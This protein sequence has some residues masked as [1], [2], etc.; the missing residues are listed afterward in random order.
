[1]KRRGTGLKLLYR[2]IGVEQTVIGV[3]KE[4]HTVDQRP[5][6]GIDAH[7]CSDIAGGDGLFEAGEGVSA[8]NE[9]LADEPRVAGV[10]Q[11]AADG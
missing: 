9:L 2:G 7:V 4:H 1:M 10:G 5:M 3:N 11:G 6:D 8:G